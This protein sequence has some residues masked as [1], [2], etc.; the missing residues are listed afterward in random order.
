MFSSCESATEFRL[1]STL[2]SVYSRLFCLVLFWAH[3]AFTD[4]LDD[5]F[6][7]LWEHQ[8][9]AELSII[10]VFA[11]DCV[12]PTEGLDSIESLVEHSVGLALAHVAHHHFHRS[13]H[14]DIG[15]ELGVDRYDRA[16]V[17]LRLL[18]KLLVCGEEDARLGSTEEL[19][20]PSA[21]G[22]CGDSQC[23][24]SGE[25]LHLCS[26]W[27]VSKVSLVLITRHLI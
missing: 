19:C 14:I 15:L 20:V 17:I 16:A 23:G 10:I 4:L 9:L 6:G 21:H 26:G 13:S 8:A 2:F 24:D 27:F 5:A 11:H 12:D 3:H 7:F 1:D 25:S 18:L 22:R